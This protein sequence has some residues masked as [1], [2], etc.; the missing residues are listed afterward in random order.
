MNDM[1]SALI[2]ILVAA[3][4]WSVFLLR[5]E[6]MKGGLV[7]LVF[8]LPACVLLFWRIPITPQAAPYLDALAM[9]SAL[10]LILFGILAMRR[11]RKSGNTG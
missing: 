10:S 11:R 2:P 7:M 4:F 8:A 6:G 3:G 1:S 9:I 5:L